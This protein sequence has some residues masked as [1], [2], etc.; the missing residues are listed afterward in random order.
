MAEFKK[1]EKLA[2]GAA[3]SVGAY[4]GGTA[5]YSAISSYVASSAATAGNVGAFAANQLGAGTLPS[6]VSQNIVDKFGIS[7]EAAD[8]TVSGAVEGGGLVVE[9]GAVALGADGLPLA[10]DTVGA[11]AGGTSAASG[12]GVATSAASGYMTLPQ[13]ISAILTMIGFGRLT[14]DPSTTIEGAPVVSQV[15]FIEAIKNM[16]KGVVSL[17]KKIPGWVKEL[18]KKAEEFLN[19]VA[20]KAIAAVA[21]VA[22]VAAILK[23]DEDNSVATASNNNT[24]NKTMFNPAGVT[25]VNDMIALVHYSTSSSGV[26]W[27]QGV[28][29]ESTDQGQY[30]NQ[31]IQTAFAST[32]TFSY[33]EVVSRA[34]GLTDALSGAVPVAGI[35]NLQQILEAQQSSESLTT[36]SIGLIVPTIPD[37]AGTLYDV[38][39]INSVTNALEYVI[40]IGEDSNTTLEGLRNAQRSLDNAISDLNIRINRDLS[41]QAEYLSQKNHMQNIFSAA[42]VYNS[43]QT[44]QPSDISDLYYSTINPNARE[45]VTLMSTM[46]DL[47]SL[48][49]TTVLNAVLTLS[50]STLLN[51]LRILG[52]PDTININSLFTMSILNGPQNGTVTVTNSNNAYSKTFDLNDIGGMT[53]QFSSVNSG[54]SV[55]RLAFSNGASYTYNIQFTPY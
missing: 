24:T 32:A 41:N 30:W 29:A 31:S 16:V 22:A 34:K 9:N 5:A 46:Q 27:A 49:T 37:M 7:V 33:F 53:Y 40:V 6:V 23:N 55:F 38:G 10:Y 35:L 19:S 3:V 17:I 12:A 44:T 54:A 15:G 42:V 21:V 1:S 50:T 25:L 36:A 51:E 47:N 39:W 43:I 2:I 8:L 14:P 4:Y 13:T 11:A 45:A 48:N 26:Y 52:I 28:Q 18:P 20:G